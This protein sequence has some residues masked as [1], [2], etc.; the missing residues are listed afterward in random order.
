[1]F[2]D[3]FWEFI[4]KEEQPSSVLGGSIAE[5][6]KYIRNLLIMHGIE[7]EK[8]LGKKHETRC[9]KEQFMYYEKSSYEYD[10]VADVKSV[11][12]YLLKTFNSGMN[13]TENAKLAAYLN[14]KGINVLF[15]ANDIAKD[16]ELVSADKKIDLLKVLSDRQTL[17]GLRSIINLLL[18]VETIKN[19]PSI[20]ETVNHTLERVN[21]VIERLNNE[22]YS[23]DL[24]KTRKYFSI[25]PMLRNPGTDIFMGDNVSC[26]LAMNS[27]IHPEAMVDRLID[28]G[29]NVIE[30][31]DEVTGK[32]MACS[33]L[34]IDTMGDLVIQNMEINSEYEAIKPL[35][36][37]VGEGMIEY[38]GKFAE[39]IGA[40][41]LLI[42]M[43]GH[44]KYFGTG[45][46]VDERYKNNSID[47]G[48]DKIGG[49]LF[50]SK[51]YLDSAG[52]PK[53]YLVSK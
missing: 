43:P 21:I 36:D 14:G 50:G 35:M 44:G 26:C 8:W 12:D 52:K 9:G 10:P 2:E 20:L 3:N 25:S 38:A 53:A 42:G 13:R 47:Y 5:H 15:D 34:Y 11:S 23:L 6:N 29:M 45:S 32:T 48:L 19:N 28:E 39:Y 16:L 24:G 4:E 17:L 51:Y 22:E 37:K 1:M 46:F 27:S 49:Y 30:V 40:K 33:W 41:R 31:K 7:Q 18:D